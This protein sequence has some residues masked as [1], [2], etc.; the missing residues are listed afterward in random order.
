MELTDNLFFQLDTDKKWLWNK[1]VMAQ[2]SG[3]RGS[4]KTY[5]LYYLL[6]CTAEI[7]ADI[8]ILDPKRSDLSSLIHCFP[9]ENQ[10]SH[11]AT[12]PN[13]ICKILREQTELMNSRYERFFQSEN[14]IMGADFRA[15]NLRP[16]FIFFDEVMAMTEEDK[17]LG[18]EAETFLKQIVLKGRQSGIYA[19][20]SSQRF[21]ADTL[22][23][24]IRENAGMRVAFGRMQSESYRMALGESFKNLP[25]APKGTGQG[26]IYL[27]GQGW[28]TPRAFTAPLMDLKQM[29]FRQLLTK[30]LNKSHSYID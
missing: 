11:V 14:S 27:D 30:F 25:R 6:L 19:I 28:N 20:I 12:S 5:F 15:Y 26:Y 21:S 23:T 24:V 13:Q 9:K 4:G 29:K 22:N 16:V 8:Y 18:K 7:G 2:I 1:E 3:P 10:N 17:K